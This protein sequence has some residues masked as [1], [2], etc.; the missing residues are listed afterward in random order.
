MNDEAEQFDDE[1]LSAYVDGELTGDQLA[2]V[3][4]RLAVDPQA[5]QLVDELRTL[6][7][8]VQSLPVE[9]V[10]DDLR[11]TIR[12]RAERA[13]LLGDEERTTSRADGDRGSRRWVWAAMALA[14]SLFLMVVMP[15]DSLD[16]KPVAVVKPA[17]D[18]EL[19]LEAAK[20]EQDVVAEVGAA[21]E[22]KEMAFGDEL[23]ADRVEVAEEVVRSAAVPSAESSAASSDV[24]S[25]VAMAPRGAAA[26][27]SRADE[28]R[29]ELQVHITFSEGD[30]RFANFDQLL[31]SNGIA[32]ESGEVRDL[33]SN[34]VG[35]YGGGYGGGIGGAEGVSTRSA[36]KGRRVRQLANESRAVQEEVVLIE[37]PSEQI[38]EVLAACSLDSLNYASVRVV[39]EKDADELPLR[40]FRQYE[41]SGQQLAKSQ[42]EQLGKRQKSAG[43][44]QQ[45]RA[46]RLESNQF[47]FEAGGQVNLEGQL[48]AK[49][50]LLSKTVPE[51]PVQVL[52]ILQQPLG[53]LA[54][55]EVG[56]AK[57]VPALER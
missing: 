37:A 31:V 49:S 40:N 34:D 25:P 32:I 2:Q 7:Q 55:A 6:S 4:Q 29:P 23:S 56:P 44:L 19:R 53:E 13:M 22:G 24:S 26:V 5:R 30:N 17:A 45:G 47:R 52:F 38:E 51:A 33:R 14:A 42:L 20:S 11:E 15:G 41:R 16:E 39:A 1:L 27:G 36:M 46:M 35:G 9:T 50:K 21:V 54:P 12:Q 48:L 28:I 3:E 8:E 43:K 57:V 10:G 18:S